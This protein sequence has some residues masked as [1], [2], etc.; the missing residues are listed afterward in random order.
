MEEELVILEDKNELSETSDD[1][2]S[3]SLEDSGPEACIDGL[4]NYN[5]ILE[6]PELDF[7]MQETLDFSAELRDWFSVADIKMLPTIASLGGER[8]VVLPDLVALLKLDDPNT[9]S[10]NLKALIKLTYVALAGFKDSGVT[11][12]SEEQLVQ[13]I[14]SN[15]NKLVST[16]GLISTLC[17]IIISRSQYLTDVS[18]NNVPDK[19]LDMWSIQFFYALTTLNIILLHY[20]T[21]SNEDDLTSGDD[22]FII[23]ELTNSSILLELMKS[24]NEWQKSSSTM[25]SKDPASILETIN[26]NNDPKMTMDKHSIKVLT[27]FKIRNVVIVFNN[28]LLLMFGNLTHLQSTKEFLDFKFDSKIDKNEYSISS[29]DY[30]YYKNELVVRYPTFT[31]PKFESSDIIKL[32]ALQSNEMEHEF[33]DLED[34]EDVE[35]SDVDSVSDILNINSLWI[36]QHQHLKNN[37]QLNGMMLSNEPPDIHIATPMP[38]P[39][40]TPQHTGS[41]RN[42]SKVSELKHP[43]SEVKKKLYVTQ[44]NY[45]NICPHDDEPPKSI[46]DALDIFYQSINDDFNTKQFISTFEQFIEKEHGIL[47]DYHDKFQY[48]N[49]DLADN[50]IFQREI[51]SL[52]MV[53]SFYSKS[54]PYFNSLIQVLIQ[55]LSSSIIPTHPTKDDS[56]SQQQPQQHQHKGNGRQRQ[57]K[58]SVDAKKVF[59]FDDLSLFDKQKLEINRMKES[60]LKSA[61]S[62]IYLLQEWFKLSHVLKFEYF[63]SLL[64]DQDYPI[65]LF[66]YLDSSKIQ[67]MSMNSHDTTEYDRLLNNTLV[68]CDF[69]ILYQKNSYNIIKSIMNMNN[70][71]FEYPP[72]LDKEE[73]INSIFN[74]MD[75]EEGDDNDNNN[76]HKPLSF[77]LPFVPNKTNFKIDSPNLRSCIIVSNLFKSMT[78]LIS[79]YKLQ[80][81]YKLLD[82]RPGEILRHFL[83]LHNKN[84]HEPILSIVKM[85]SPFMGKKWRTNNMDLISFVYLFDTIGIKDIWLNNIINSSIDDRI[86]KSFDNEFSL[87]CLIKFYNF[88]NY[89]DGKIGIEN[90][91]NE[92]EFFNQVDKF[93]GDFFLK[94]CL[95]L[96]N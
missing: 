94:G 20:N 37:K 53:E 59:D 31:P 44:A 7:T 45:P 41:S 56:Q 28:L 84:F 78:N 51:K 66:R 95:N 82:L 6:H 38:S 2:S 34:P 61:T 1:H 14:K 13:K 58:S 79:N 64:Y 12:N 60:M 47:I 4:S 71:R 49:E 35:D 68:Y 88:E 76:H 5:I 25:E 75:E 83:T 86:N 74:K 24:I 63:S 80:R 32:T 67:A 9:N 55:I 92:V 81:I 85:V 33:D 11:F 96:N 65:Y 57:V 46:K 26:S 42:Y 8:N 72:P 73:V 10:E 43:T 90:Y 52:Q 15:V 89:G 77:I 54:L 23:D 21:Y 48:G 30:E 91:L 27:S 87:R 93:Q 17:R 29:M 50:P 36:N 69:T 19:L 22:S 70:P 3:F 39:T 40:L 16:E 62:I 18:L